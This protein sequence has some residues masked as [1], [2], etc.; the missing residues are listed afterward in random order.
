MI[1]YVTTVGHR[2]SRFSKIRRKGARTLILFSSFARNRTELPFYCSFKASLFL[3]FDT[4]CF[5]K[6]KN[7]ERHFN[8]I[9]FSQEESTFFMNL[10]TFLLFIR[11]TVHNMQLQKVYNT[12]RA[13]CPYS[14]YTTST[15]TF[16]KLLCVTIT[17]LIIYTL[18]SCPRI[19]DRLMLM[20]D[21]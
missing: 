4:L 20:A 13:M 3:Q 16:Q 17:L 12:K 14:L 5:I 11:H 15:E 2:L 19:H 10:A 6:G 8:A 9:S 18:H 1:L 21:D 7:I